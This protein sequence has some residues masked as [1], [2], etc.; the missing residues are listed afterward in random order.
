MAENGGWYKSKKAWALTVVSGVFFVLDCW[1][2]A[3]IAVEIYHCLPSAVGLS[4]FV[5]PALFVVTL[6]LFETQRRRSDVKPAVK[7]KSGQSRNILWNWVAYI[8][9]ILVFVI[10]SVF[11]IVKPSMKVEVYRDMIGELRGAT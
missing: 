9:V 10:V 7:K 8:A 11:S 6:A 3:E 5:S 4:P 2:R 1:G